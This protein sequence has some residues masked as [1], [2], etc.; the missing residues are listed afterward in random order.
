VLTSDPPEADFVLI[1]EDSNRTLTGSFPAKLDRLRTGS[2]RLKARRPGF[3]RELKVTVPRNETNR[4]LVKFEYG[5]AKI[6]TT[7]EG[8]TVIWA[9]EDR[10]KTPLTLTRIVPG[11]YRIELRLDGYVPQAGD[12]AVTADSPASLSVSLVN[13]GYRTAMEAAKRH[14]ENNHFWDAT[15]QLGGALT[16]IPG[17]PEASALLAKVRPTAVRERARQLGSLNDYGGAVRV[18]DAYL[19]DSPGDKES[20]ELREQ[21]STARQ[22]LEAKQIETKVQE[23]M[24]DARATADRKQFD[25]ALSLLEAAQK[26]APSNLRISQLEASIRTARDQYQADERAKKSAAE[27]A[28]R[29]N[30]YRAAWDRAQRADP[31]ANL[32]PTKYWD[33]TK[34]I[35]EVREAITQIGSKS[36]TFKVS[37][38]SNDADFYFTAKIG[39]LSPPIQDGYYFKIGVISIN[40][41]KTQI[42]AKVFA[43]NPVAGKAVPETNKN[44]LQ[45]RLERLRSRLSEQFGTPLY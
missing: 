4:V 27:I 1:P 26:L 31:N 9:G 40:S 16:A 20:S 21:M 32:F 6:S 33:T 18:L 11:S 19:A 42:S 37:E 23:L 30:Q 44:I 3:E 41:G 14:L 38:L 7:P 35:S 12:L 17:D 15:I 25:Q 34:T 28:D 43:Y 24:V 39:D 5:S 2:Y 45:E 29:G 36:T 10:G 22:A 8:A 13:A